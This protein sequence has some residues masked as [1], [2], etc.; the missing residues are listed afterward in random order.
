MSCQTSCA[1]VHVCVSCS[2]FLI[3]KLL[4]LE[5]T[6]RASD[7]VKNMIESQDVCECATAGTDDSSLII[8]PYP[9]DQT[10]ANEHRPLKTILF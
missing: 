2:F 5:L 10:R 7:G 8:Q 6:H 9:N 1:C 4:Q 3:S